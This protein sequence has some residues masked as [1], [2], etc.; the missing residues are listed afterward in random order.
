MYFPKTVNRALITWFGCGRVPFAPGT[1]GSLGALPLCWLL[2]AN[3]DPL[4]RVLVAVGFTAI[5]CL[6]SAQDQATGGQRDP[7]YIVIDEVVG[8]LWSTILISAHWIPMLIAFVFFRI[9]DILKP[10]PAIFFDRW[11]KTS[12]SIARRG[13]H[14]VLDDVVAGI[15]A[16]LVTQ[17]ILMYFLPEIPRFSF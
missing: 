7:N 9:F 10:H 12:L 4:F 13:A 5:A 3:T 16:L 11:S 8:M 17:M 6:A 14:I 1:M 2:A 15:Y